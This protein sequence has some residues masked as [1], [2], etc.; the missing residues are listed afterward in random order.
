MTNP[1]SVKARLRQLSKSESKPFDY[2]M[3]HYFVERLLYRLSVSDYA[4]NF[5]LKGGLLLY[6]IL[7]ND[8]RAT[9]DVDFLARRLNNAP[10]ELIS[11]FRDICAI[12]ADDAV[13][14]DLASI[15]AERI[16]EGAEYE[17]VRVKVT[18]YLDKSRHVMQFDVGFGDV[19][20]PMPITIDY[21]SLLDM[22]RPRIQA[23]SQESVIAEKFE[24]MIA[25][26]EVNSRMK[27]FYDVYMLSRL[28]GFDGTVLIEAVRQTLEHR[29][30]P[31]SAAPSVFSEAFANI[32]DKQVQWQ[33]FQRRIRVAENISLPEVLERIRTFLQPV[34]LAILSKS[35]WKKRW[36]HVDAQWE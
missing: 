8:A 23:Y 22:E 12:E 1:D 25:L 14:F 30:T 19:V 10:V 33:A 27:D 16:K 34:Y 2:L 26:A 18:G 31:L 35:E 15:I 7:E 36:N 9:R 4:D 24:A 28:F 21:P 5:I 29:M 11:V 13:R 32:P 6:T 20:V 17:G 3:M